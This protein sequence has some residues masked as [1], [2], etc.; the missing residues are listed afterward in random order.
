MSNNV[1]DNLE[2][3]GQQNIVHCCFHQARTGCAFLA[4]YTAKNQILL[5]TGC[6]NVVGATLFLVVNN[7]EQYC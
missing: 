5:K 7:I 4:V 3:C 2:Q 6:S 1:D